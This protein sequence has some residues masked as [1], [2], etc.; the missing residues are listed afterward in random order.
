MDDAVKNVKVSVKTNK[1][2]KVIGESTKALTFKTQ[3]DQVVNFELDVAE[4]I[5]KATVQIVATSGKEKSTYEIELDVRNPNL[6][7][8][9]IEET[10][11][12]AGSIWSHDMPLHGMNGTNSAK[13]EVSTIP[14]INLEKRLN[15]L[16]RYP[17]GCIEQTT[18]SVF[19]QLYLADIMEVD[20]ELKV[21]I[22]NNITA[23]INKIQ[24]HQLSDGGFAYWIGS[25]SSSDWGSSYAGHFLLEAEKKGYALPYGVKKQWIN[26][27]RGQA[28][29]WNNTNSYYYN[30]DL[31]QAYRLYTLC[32]AGSPE[33]SVMNRL[34]ESNDL[35]V[36]AAWRLAAAYQVIGKNEVAKKLIS[37]RAT[38]VKPYREL[39]YTYGSGTRDQ[40]MI[41]ETLVL[42]GEKT[43]AAPL[44]KDL[45]EELSSNHWMSTQ[46]TAYALKAIS[47]FTKGEKGKG[48]LNY[49][50]TYNGESQSSSTKKQQTVKTDHVINI[51]D[52]DVKNKQKTASVSVKNNGSDILFVRVVADGIPLA[53]DEQ[54]SSENLNLSVVYKNTAGDVISVDRLD[55]GMD[56]VAEVTIS[57][58]G[59]KG[60][61]REM[62][63]SQ[64]FPSGWEIH[65]SR[66]DIGGNTQSYD[67][68]EYQDIRDDR[69]FTYF[70]LQRNSSKTFKINLHAA[71]IGDFYLPA[72]RCG[73]MYDN[74]ISALRKGKRISVVKPG[75]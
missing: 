58:P 70:D 12:E 14:P 5:G 28:Q 50:Y 2:L 73:A 55:Q 66:M 60:D 52:L 43:K 41:I 20:S 61:Y 9:K 26:Y 19:P 63:L 44:V 42:M 23:A 67:A 64:L 47:D 39:S 29:K 30:S 36:Q 68:F 72:V 4:T 25:N 21:R 57:N 27:Q 11:I 48:G 53:G 71:Y 17:H 46:T 7:V 3:G 16:I 13:I 49:T 22:Q 56:F 69:V 40:A 65:N 74:T 31:A 37:N 24:K 45:S 54:S 59:M 18:S 10:V 15:Y 35:S 51:T 6:P 62:A 8:T 32:L 33:L 34:R 1:M 75:S 38:K